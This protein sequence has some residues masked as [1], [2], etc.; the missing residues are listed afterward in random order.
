MKKYKYAIYHLNK[1]L[2]MLE[3][4]YNKYLKYNRFYS[5]LDGI[6]NTGSRNIKNVFKINKS[7]NFL[8][9]KAYKKKRN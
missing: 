4:R 3:K 6:I 5:L 7:W 2:N 9:F 8:R 1:R